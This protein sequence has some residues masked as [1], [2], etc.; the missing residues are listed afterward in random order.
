MRKLKGK[1]RY[2]ESHLRNYLIALRNKISGESVCKTLKISRQYLSDLTLG[3]RAISDRVA[4]R[5]G[6]KR[7]VEFEIFTTEGNEDE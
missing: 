4:S 1:T 7:I 3:K 2:D 5:L 6:Y